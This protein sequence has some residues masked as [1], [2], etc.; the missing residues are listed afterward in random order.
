MDLSEKTDN[1]KELN[2]KVLSQAQEINLLE[3]KLDTL[4]SQ[5]ENNTDG[6]EKLMKNLELLQNKVQT[7][8]A[9]IDE[10]HHEQKTIENEYKA[11][12][13][14]LEYENAQLSEEILR[15]RAKNSQYD[16]EAQ[17]YE[18]NQLK[19]ENTQL[20]D[21]VKKYLN[22]FKELKDKE[23]EHAHQIAFYE[24]EFE[25]AEKENE[26]YGKK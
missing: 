11:K 21:N 5:F 24:L 1:L 17:H 8:E 19:Q 23:V 12:I 18:I 15:I 25:K 26:N 3:T 14:D 22:N 6:N 9:S 2:N 7:Q 16:P 20:K 4:N 10:L 13:K